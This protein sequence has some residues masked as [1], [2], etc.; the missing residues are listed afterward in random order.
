[1][2]RPSFLKGRARGADRGGRAGI[3]PP[4]TG[5]TYLSPCLT[6]ELRAPSPAPIL[7]EDAAAHLGFRDVTRADTTRLRETTSPRGRP[8]RVRHAEGHLLPLARDTPRR[9]RR[10]P[11]H[12]S[13]SSLSLSRSRS[14]DFSLSRAREIVTLAPRRRNVQGGACGKAARSQCRC[15]LP[16]VICQGYDGHHHDTTIRSFAEDTFSQYDTFSFCEKFLAVSSGCLLLGVQLCF[17][18]L[19]VNLIMY[20]TVSALT[21]RTAFQDRHTIDA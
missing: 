18:N 8:P 13:R 4:E 3:S 10:P 2:L 6:S 5:R 12:P 17:V 19:F 15:N 1:M 11:L 14:L 16:R 20:V 21:Q 9:A 7:R